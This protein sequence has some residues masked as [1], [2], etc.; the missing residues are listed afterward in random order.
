VL[1]GLDLENR[2]IEIDVSKI[3]S[4]ASTLTD[5]YSEQKLD[6]I[7]GIVKVKPKNGSLG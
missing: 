6:V 2:L 7:D 3:F 4:N 1:I 5:F